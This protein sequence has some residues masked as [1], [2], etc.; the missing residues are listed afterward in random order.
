MSETDQKIPERLE[1]DPWDR[2]NGNHAADFEDDVDAFA[3]SIDQCGG[4]KDD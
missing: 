3:G 2:S 4:G 1:L